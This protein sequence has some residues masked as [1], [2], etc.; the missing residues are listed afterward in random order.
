MYKGL[1][2]RETLRS[3]DGVKYFKNTVRPHFIKGALSVFLW[4][5]FK[6]IRAKGEN[7]EMV[8]WVGKFSLLL[9]RWKDAWMDMLPTSSMSETRRQNQYHADVARENEE[10]RSRSHELLHQDLPETREEWNATQVA[11]H[12]RL[13]PF[14]DNLRT[15]VFIVPSDLSEAHR[16]RLTSSRSLQAVHI[17]ACTFERVRTVFVE[18]VL[19]VKKVKWRI[20]HSE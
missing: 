2:D 18:I 1:L 15:L 4:R 17:T 8:K 14:S 5:F 9:K 19:Y 20:L 3:E 12:E 7:M 6:F 13:F 11:A 16:E 10:R